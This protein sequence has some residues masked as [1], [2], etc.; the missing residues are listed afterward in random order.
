MLFGTSTSW[1]HSVGVQT[2]WKQTTVTQQEEVMLRVSPETR[3]YLSPPTDMRICTIKA[4]LSESAKF[5]II[6]PLHFRM[7]VSF[8]LPYKYRNTRGSDKITPCYA[9]FKGGCKEMESLNFLVFS[10]FC[11]IVDQLNAL[12]CPSFFFSYLQGV[13]GAPLYQL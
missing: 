1:G 8:V 9:V 11:L 13:M 4:V 6:F 12:Y 5:S 10:S 7:T 2:C 3:K